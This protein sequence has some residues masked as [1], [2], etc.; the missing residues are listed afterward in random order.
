MS[1]EAPMIDESSPRLGVFLCECGGVIGDGID[2]EALA[3]QAAQLPGVVYVHHEAYP[4]SK[5]GQERLRQAVQEYG[6]ERVLVAGC[7]PRL[8]E[9]L[10]DGAV[11][12]TQI[13]PGCLMVTNIRELAALNHPGD[14]QA[15]GRAAQGAVAMGAARLATTHPSPPH[16]GQV[17]KSAL[18]I[19]SGLSGLSVA[20]ALAGRDIPVTVIEAEEEFAQT[21]PDLDERTRQMAQERKQAALSSPLIRL[22]ANTRLAAVNGHPGEYEAWLQQGGQT[23]AIAVGAIILANAAR[24]KLLGSEHWFERSKV[25]TQAEFEAEL[26]GADRS[27]AGLGLQNVVMILCAEESQQTRCSRVCCNIGIR[28][29]LRVKQLNPDAA[30]TVLFRELYLPGSD[31]SGEAELL[32]ARK[33]GVTFFRYRDGFPPILGDKTIDVQDRLTGEPVRIEYDRV[34]LSMPLIPVEHTRALA[35]LLGLPQDE[36]GF[37]AEPRVRLRPGRYAD[38]GIFVLGSAHQPADTAE[39]LFQAY[40]TSA[41][42]LHFL[43]QETIRVEAPAAEID[44]A[45]CTGCGNCPQVCPVNAIQLE[46]RD[47]VLSVSAVDALRC[48]GCGNCVVVCPVKAISLPGWDA[49]E[50]PAQISAALDERGFKEGQ[51]KVLCLAC[52]WSAYG[53]AES[54]GHREI[55]APDNFRVLRLNCS[56]RFDPFHILWAF[57]NGADGVLLGACAP[58]ECHYGLGNLYAR[59]RVAALQA[60]LE[61]HGIDPCRLQL[62]YFSVQDGEKFARVANHFEQHL[63]QPGS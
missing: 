7:A 24:P 53:A 35:A 28:Q 10:F 32:Q 9:K 31:G 47:G 52:E 14:P 50:I 17:R 15:A 61:R 62:E 18:V 2:L 63:S 42:V 13:A 25:K 57:L 26:E 22:Q 46:R 39:A 43:G 5:D 58:G 12:P 55:A 56:A 23:S 48:V 41:R 49:L 33:L 37:L 44:S 4:C 8:V 3:Q 59:E 45:L 30:V 51:P 34:V 19:G 16:F 40:L 6:L 27:E 60:E 36:A 20:L 1:D 38:S 11:Q 54:A 21:L 29:A